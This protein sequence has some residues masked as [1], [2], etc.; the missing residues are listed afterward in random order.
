MR[1]DT[2]RYDTIRYDTIQ[3]TMKYDAIQY[4]MFLMACLYR[5]HLLFNAS[6]D[7]KS[8]VYDA[9]TSF[10]PQ[11]FTV[12]IFLHPL[13]KHQLIWQENIWSSPFQKSNPKEQ[14]PPQYFFPKLWQI[15]VTREQITCADQTDYSKKKARK[16]CC[17]MYF[18]ANLMF[19]P[20]YQ[21]W[22]DKYHL[23]FSF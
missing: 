7:K 5:E 16:I 10:W 18:A 15:D 4:E 19:G 22:S 23:S 21:S 9:A 1:C 13:E 6:L 8:A 3:N 17:C 11:R 14:K 2:I 12:K 20:D